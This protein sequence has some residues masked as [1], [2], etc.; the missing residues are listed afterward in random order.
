MFGASFSSTRWRWSRQGVAL[1]IAISTAVLA[2]SGLL[3]AAPSPSSSPAAA[4]PAPGPRTS[5][6]SANLAFVKNEAITT[7][8]SEV[9]TWFRQRSAEAQ[10]V[11]H[12]EEVLFLVSN[13]QIARQVLELGFA[14]A[15]GQVALNAKADLSAEQQVAAHRSP[16]LRELSARGDEIGA[17][18]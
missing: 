10:L 16:F 2:A 1:A 5:P 4:S 13:Q 15:R 11:D 8:L 6:V 9:I 3:R 12:P 14:A 18:L 17:N 7:Y